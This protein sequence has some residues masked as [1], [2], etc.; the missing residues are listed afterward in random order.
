[1]GGVKKCHIPANLFSLLFDEPTSV[2]AM[3]VIYVETV[4]D[5]DFIKYV[6]EKWN[7]IVT[8]ESMFVSW[9]P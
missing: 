7:S 2:D 3:Q 1:M 6:Q 8:W 9:L 4:L 5:L